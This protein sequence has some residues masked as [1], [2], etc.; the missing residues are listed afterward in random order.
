[1]KVNSVVFCSAKQYKLLDRSTG[2][3]DVQLIA[4]ASLGSKHLECP[5]EVLDL[6]DLDY[7]VS[8]GAANRRIFLTRSPTTGRTISNYDEVG[9]VFYENTT[10]NISIPRAWHSPS[11]LNYLVNVAT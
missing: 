4:Q 8:S 2:A 6:L 11:R 5:A 10:S 9:P 7:H 3:S 1:M